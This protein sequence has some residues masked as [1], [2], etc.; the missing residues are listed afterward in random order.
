MNITDFFRKVFGRQK[1]NKPVDNG[2]PK[3]PPQKFYTSAKPYVPSYD[4]HTKFH[5]RRRDDDTSAIQ[6]ALM[7]TAINDVH[8]RPV[9]VVTPSTS[10]GISTYTSESSYERDNSSSSESSYSSSDTSAGVSTE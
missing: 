7:M 1:A 9:Q 5:E 3:F 10:Y 4:A 2:G 6:T 8:H